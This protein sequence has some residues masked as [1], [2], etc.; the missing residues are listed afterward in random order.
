MVTIDWSDTELDT[1]V[2]VLQVDPHDRGSILGTLPFN[3][4]SISYGYYTDT[5]VSAKVSTYDADQLIGG[6]WLRIVLEVVGTD[7]RNDLFTGYISGLDESMEAGATKTD[8]ELSSALKAI[9]GDASTA[10]FCVGARATAQQAIAAAMAK[11]GMPYFVSPTAG[12]YRYTSQR[13]Y[14]PG[15]SWLS[16]LFDLAG[17]A[18]AH[19]DVDGRGIVTFDG[20]TPPASASPAWVMDAESKRSIVLSATV[21]R[22]SD[23]YERPNRSIVIFKDDDKII[24]GYADL[25]GGSPNSAARRGVVLAEVHE[26]DDMPSPRSASQAQRMAQQYLQSDAASSV[27]WSVTAMLDPTISCGSVGLFNPGGNQGVHKVL[28][29]SVDLDPLTMRMDLELK[30]V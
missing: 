28:V 1:S 19:I 8:L 22:S 7:Y 21:S 16:T 23:I 25:G 12:D 6:A 30:E 3:S 9:E 4:V 27:E 2:S 10:L 20:Y 24:S 17:A 5:R 14:D 15:E 29:T 11:T 26:L 18:G 13:M